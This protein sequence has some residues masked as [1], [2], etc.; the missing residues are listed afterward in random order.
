VGGSSEG[1]GLQGGTEVGLLEV[2]VVPPLNSAV[3]GELASSLKT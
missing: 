2:L 3:V 1:I